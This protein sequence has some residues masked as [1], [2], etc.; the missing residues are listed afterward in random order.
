MAN[1]VQFVFQW[2]VRTAGLLGQ[3]GLNAQ[4]HVEVGLNKGGALVTTQA[5][6]VLA[7]R[8]RHAS[9]VWESVT[10]EFVRMVAGAC[11]L[12]GHPAQ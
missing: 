5:T 3:N 9:A 10:A 7:H 12:P 8:F 1:A 4:S 2:T 6:H 11:G